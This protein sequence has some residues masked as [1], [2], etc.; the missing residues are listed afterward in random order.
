MERT[1][2]RRGR[3]HS[4][5][6]HRMVPGVFAFLVVYTASSHSI[7]TLLDLGDG[8]VQFCILVLIN[9]SIDQRQILHV[10]SSTS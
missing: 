1:G 5:E 8:A 7:C 4:M 3:V 10:M 9:Q 6:G 2:L